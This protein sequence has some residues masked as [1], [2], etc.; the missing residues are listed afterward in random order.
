MF[1]GNNLME[2]NFISS[3]LINF[4]AS[5]FFVCLFVICFYFMF[6]RVKNLQI[7]S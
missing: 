3:L 6:L 4:L 5:F 2:K 1:G 7:C